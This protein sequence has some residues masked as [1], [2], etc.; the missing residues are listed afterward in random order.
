MVPVLF[1]YGMICMAADFLK[2]EESALIQ[3]I[4]ILSSD[5]FEGRAPG[6]QGESRSVDYIESQLKSFGL[7][8]G[9]LDGTCIKECLP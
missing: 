4:K 9:N 7:E 8:P 6:T 5:A 2:I 1:V 3:H